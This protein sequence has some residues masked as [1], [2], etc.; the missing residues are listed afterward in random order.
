MVTG[1]RETRLGKTMQKVTDKE[2]KKRIE[3]E[4]EPVPLYERETEV[5]G[6]GEEGWE[7]ERLDVLYSKMSESHK[8]SDNGQTST[9]TTGVWRCWRVGEGEPAGWN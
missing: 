7:A 8:Q 6:G 3:R 9:S 4:R 1:W 2:R 5:D